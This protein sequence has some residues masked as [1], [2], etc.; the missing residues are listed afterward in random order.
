MLWLE[1]SGMVADAKLDKEKP[2][3]TRAKWVERITGKKKKRKANIQSQPEML[4]KMNRK[5]T[6]T[7]KVQDSKSLKIKFHPSKVSVTSHAKE[8]CE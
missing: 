2:L 6:L 8:D 4:S 3:S 1:G 5:L 7:D